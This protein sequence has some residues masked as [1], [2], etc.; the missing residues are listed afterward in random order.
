[1]GWGRRFSAA[2]S[3]GPDSCFWLLVIS[4]FHNPHIGKPPSRM[5]RHPDMDRWPGTVEPDHPSCHLLT[6]VRTE[7]GFMPHS[8]PISYFVICHIQYINAIAEYSS[9]GTIRGNPICLSVI[10]H[11]LL[12]APHPAMFVVPFQA[13]PS[14]TGRQV[15]SALDFCECF[16]DVHLSS[17]IHSDRL[18]LI[19]CSFS[20]LIS[21]A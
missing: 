5:Y 3:I 4:R 16:Y 12:L 1:M 10:V 8:L 9:R 11:H 13:I 6:I 18:Y 20:R 14:E 7:S 19:I 2:R 15:A 17:P 21:S